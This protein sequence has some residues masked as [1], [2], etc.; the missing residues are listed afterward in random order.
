[1]HGFLRAPDGKITVFDPPGSQQTEAITLNSSH[2]VVGYYYDLN[3]V[4]RG[5]LREP[6]G[7]YTIIEP[8]GSI[9]GW[10]ITP[11]NINES[12][13]I[14]GYY[15]GANSIWHV[16]LRSPEGKFTVYEAPAQATSSLTRNMG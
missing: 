8:P 16:F 6:D 2:Q 13:E 3:G 9:L 4:Q 15:L 12:G 14:S 5:F 1:M 7:A 10:P 11:G